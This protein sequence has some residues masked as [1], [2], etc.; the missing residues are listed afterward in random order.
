MYNYRVGH[1]ILRAL[2]I[3]ASDPQ[4]VLAGISF[5]SPK[6]LCSLPLPP[7]HFPVLAI[8]NFYY[9]YYEIDSVL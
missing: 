5:H 9:F 4:N 1:K 3:R 8:F 6:S 7:P 2:A